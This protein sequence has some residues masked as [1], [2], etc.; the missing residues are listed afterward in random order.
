[1]PARIL[2][3]AAIGDEVGEGQ[4]KKFD[5][6][7]KPFLIRRAA[8]IERGK[9]RK[10][11]RSKRRRL[12]TRSAAHKHS[13]FLP[14]VRYYARRVGARP[15]GI[16]D[17]KQVVSFPKHFSFIENADG[18]LKALRTLVGVC[19]MP[20]TSVVDLDHEHCTLTDHGAASVMNALALETAARRRVGFSGTYPRARDQRE[21]MWATG[22]PRLLKSVGPEQPPDFHPFPL[23]KGVLRSSSWEESDLGEKKADELTRY[24]DSCV[25][26]YGFSLTPASKVNLLKIAG[27][28]LG[29]AEEHPDRPEWWVSGYLRHSKS[30]PYGDCHLTIF[31]FG[32]TMAE[33]LQTLP[34]GS[35]LR[36][37]I[38]RLVD[39]HRK[40]GF[41]FRRWTPE[42]LWTL[43]ALQEGV[44]CTNAEAE[45]SGRGNG[46][47]ELIKYF[48][49]LGRVS[50]RDVQPKMTLISGS[51]QI[52][53]DDEYRIRERDVH[54][55]PKHI[56]AFNSENDLELPPDER[57]V[58]RLRYYFPGTLLSLRF[59]LDKGHL[60]A[61]PETI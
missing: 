6:S 9:R 55:E 40:L 56:I 57:N 35:V 42:N 7:K 61:S 29:N 28:V 19:C 13:R 20:S 22:L 2:P 27:E 32:M 14:A 8:K 15:R 33:S 51:T 59:Y 24:V 44:S 41:F 16:K 31:S 11:E 52:L 46:T 38:E 49:E 18:T 34:H 12:Q 17:V 45:P 39:K 26:R 53:F 60:Q 36:E 23:F 3:S 50:Q 37:R 21:I 58:R 54:G 4:I 10:R 43:Y 5:K 1:M 47:V 48:Q 25:S 30:S